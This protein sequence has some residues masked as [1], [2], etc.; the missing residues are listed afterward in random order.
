MSDQ[1]KIFRTIV[2]ATQALYPSS[3]TTNLDIEKI[4]LPFEWVIFPDFLQYEWNILSTKQWHWQQ[5]FYF[6]MC[7]HFES[8]TLKFDIIKN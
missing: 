5:Y 8:K 7:Q 4:F 2:I 1:I 6:T 3:Y